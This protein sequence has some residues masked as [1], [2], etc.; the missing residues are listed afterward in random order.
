[1]FDLYF[2]PCP[3]LAFQQAMD[4]NPLRRKHGRRQ[5][6]SRG[7]TRYH[8]ARIPAVLYPGSWDIGS[9]YGVR[10]RGRFIGASWRGC[11]AI[12]GARP[13][14][15]ARPI[16]GPGTSTGTATGRGRRLFNDF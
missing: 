7:I 4:L 14:A 13:G 3:A 5:T 9:C 16:P 1:M 11:P 6:G 8:T 10:R 15:T 12:A 2:N